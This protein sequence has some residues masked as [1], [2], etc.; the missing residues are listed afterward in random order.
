MYLNQRV[1]LFLP[2]NAI[3]AWFCNRIYLRK[4]LLVLMLKERALILLR[5][6]HLMILRMKIIVLKSTKQ[7]LSKVSPMVHA[8]Q[9]TQL[10][11]L[12]HHWTLPAAWVLVIL[13]I[14]W[15]TTAGSEEMLTTR[16]FMMCVTLMFYFF[17]SYKHLFHSNGFSLCDLNC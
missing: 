8:V 12:M 11:F 15:Q 7:N 5:T 9:L 17:L 1:H 3:S 6:G 4:Q 10:S 13:V 2:H 14:T 16:N